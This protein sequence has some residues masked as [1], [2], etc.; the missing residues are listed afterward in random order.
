MHPYAL[1]YIPTQPQVFI[2]VGILLAYLAGLPYQYHM[3]VLPIAG[4]PIPWWRVM[5]LM[6]LIP[7]VA[8][9]LV[10]LSCPESPIWLESRDKERADE[11]WVKLWGARAILYEAMPDADEAGEEEERQSLLDPGMDVSLIHHIWNNP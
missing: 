2:N 1:I 9:L 5:I 3:E 6:A 7:A 4:L 8:Q 10:L 11:A